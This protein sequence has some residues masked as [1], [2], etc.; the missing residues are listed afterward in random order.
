MAILILNKSKLIW[1]FLVF[2]CFISLTTFNKLGINAVYINIISASL[3]GMLLYNDF[4]VNKQTEKV[5][6][7]L[8]L[9]PFFYFVSSI[10]HLTSFD[11]LTS[12]KETIRVLL[13]FLFGYVFLLFIRKDFRNYTFIHTVLKVFFYINCFLL[14]L[15]YLHS[16]GIVSTPLETK[17]YFTNEDIK[18]YSYYQIWGVDI[19]FEKFSGFFAETQEFSLFV[20]GFYVFSD[21][22]NRR[23]LHL[24]SEKHLLFLQIFIFFMLSKIVLLGYF[25]YKFF[26][27]RINKVLKLTL[28][29]I[30]V[31]LLVGLIYF[32]FELISRSSNFNFIPAGSLGE[33]YFH[34]LIILEHFQNNIFD[35]LIGLSPRQYGLLLITEYNALAQ[36][37]STNLNFNIDTNAMSIFKVLADIGVV[38]FLFYLSSFAIL[39]LN[40]GK[41]VR[42]LLVSF[43]IANSFIPNN[44]SYI[45]IF[46]MTLLYSFNYRIE[47]AK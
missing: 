27:M 15:A 43:F 8:M 21:Q 42:I 33:R 17:L 28:V 13:V 32:E 2:F 10:L 40:S 29:V 22:M 1:S 37:F 25:F 9:T 34:L 44:I 30:E 7:V 31:I 38:G 4:T 12:L 14:L 19:I 41:E 46:F 35:L 20:F 26:T 47:N 5:F 45:F 11:N 16:L 3:I 6:M 24:S 23:K 39:V 18:N 36:S